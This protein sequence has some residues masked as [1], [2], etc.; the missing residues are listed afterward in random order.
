M[1]LLLASLA[2]IVSAMVGPADAAD[3]YVSLILGS[4]HFG[5][6]ELNDN[7]P[8]LTYGNR[9]AG[10]RENTEWF[11][12]GGVFYNSY[13]EVSPIALFGTSMSVGSIGS[14]D[15]RIGAAV[16]V[17]YYDELS[18]RLKDRYGL[19]NLNG[20]IPIVAASIAVREGS[21][22]VRLTALPPD[23]DTGFVVN[24]SY[25]RSF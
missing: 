1:R 22:E 9:W 5:N 16:G 3:K 20:F 11:L 18:K 4:K 17:A 25:A 8:G 10:K 7:T 23:K 2:I 14:A 12:E 6:D 19:P 13:E 15:V 24:L 21:N